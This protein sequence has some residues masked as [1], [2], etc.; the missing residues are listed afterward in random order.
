MFITKEKMMKKLMLV[1]VL[2]SAQLVNASELAKVQI[3]KNLAG[4]KSVGEINYGV[5]KELERAWLEFTASDSS[6]EGY[7][8]E[9]REKIEGLKYDTTLNAITFSKDNKTVVCR[10]FVTKRF[11]GRN[12]QSYKNTGNCRKEETYQ[13]VIIDDGFNMVKRE[14]YIVNFVV[15]MSKAI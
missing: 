6:D 3:Y 11:L 1:L 10:Q 12:I 9:Y 4:W 5:N 13:K 7:G 14:Y 2:M 8:E 15:D